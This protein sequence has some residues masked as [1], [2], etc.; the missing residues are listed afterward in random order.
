M[1][2]I[3]G[4]ISFYEWRN[5]NEVI[6][7]PRSFQ[8]P[9]TQPVTSVEDAIMQANKR[10][11]K[12]ESILNRANKFG[13]DNL[14]KVYVDVKKE[15][16]I[17]D[18]INRPGKPKPL[19]KIGDFL[20]GTISCPTKEYVVEVTEWF[21]KPENQKD[22]KVN[23]YESKAEAREG[24][25]TGYSGSYHVDIIIDGMVCEIQIMTTNLWGVKH[26][27]HK[28]GYMAGR[29]GK[30]VDPQVAHDARL[31]FNRLKKDKIEKPKPSKPKFKY[32]PSK[33]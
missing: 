13:S 23:A 30:G 4:L 31:I 20:R 3:M 9:F 25:V 2:I 29:S 32:N 24:D 17:L 14:G 12:F 5:L 15:A 26:A 1:E 10:M 19:N 6:L 16:S 18:K 11:P 7:P 8:H 27:I 21:L 22:F 28:Y 33:D